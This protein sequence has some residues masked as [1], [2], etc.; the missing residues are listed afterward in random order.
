MA[1]VAALPATGVRGADGSAWQ[2]RAHLWAAPTG[3]HGEGSGMR[4]QK[5][6]GRLGPTG[7]AWSDE[8]REAAERETRAAEICGRGLGK[9]WRLGRGDGGG[10]VCGC[11]RAGARAM[12][13][14]VMG[15]RALTYCWRRCGRSSRLP[16][17]GE[18]AVFLFVLS[19]G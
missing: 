19:A 11:V 2:A 5:V 8:K 17:P 12:K 4:G 13:C 16:V 18:P 15:A 6:S 1:A 14:W 3:A 7:G 10:W 9:Q